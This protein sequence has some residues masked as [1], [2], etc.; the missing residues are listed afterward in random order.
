MEKTK[1]GLELIGK[2]FTGFSDVQWKQWEQLGDLYKHWNS[3]I[4]V[5]SRKDIDN[6]YEKH[7]LHS[8][9]VAVRFEFEP[10]ATVLDIGTGG[11]FP[12]IPLAIFF[13]DTCFH[14]VDRI[15]KKIKVVEAV[16]AATGLTNLTAQHGRVEDLGKKKFDH[17]VS[18]AVAPLHDLWSWSKPL[19]RIGNDWIEPAGAGIK[20]LP[21]RM[22]PVPPFLPEPQSRQK[23]KGLISLKGGSLSA[24]IALSGCRPYVMDIHEFF[25]EPYF[26]E[27]FI[28]FVPSGTPPA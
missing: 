2:Y 14:L 22:N 4:N 28:L 20:D 24:E 26:L 3:K 21:L 16:A 19:L 12:G 23:E 9:A 25:P 7:I 8:L 11:G 15:G 5:I 10:G 27:K 1:A 13:P 18:R 6:L 17:I